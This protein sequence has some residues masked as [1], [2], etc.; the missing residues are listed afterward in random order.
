MKGSWSEKH[1]PICLRGGGRPTCEPEHGERDL[2]LALGLH[3]GEDQVPHGGPLGKCEALSGSV[4]TVMTRIGRFRS[5][6]PRTRITRA[7]R[8][9][10]AGC[11]HT[12]KSPQTTKHNIKCSPMGGSPA[13]CRLSQNEAAFVM[14]LFFIMN[15]WW[16]CPIFVVELSRVASGAV[17]CNF[18]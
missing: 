9:R 12:K 1:T 15:R 4:A 18:F 17:C 8:L 6:K 11:L 10:K 13:K 5:K 2:A 3:L 16:G 14:H 7:H